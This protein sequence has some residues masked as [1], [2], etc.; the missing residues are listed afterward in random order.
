MAVKKSKA[1]QWFKIIA[2]KM[3]DEKEIGT[4]LTFTPENLVGKTI[5]LSAIELTNDMSKYYLKLNFKITKVEGD[6]AL[7]A[8]YGFDCMHDYIARMVVRRVRRI[9]AVQN[10]VTKDGVKITVKS[11]ATIS[12]KATSS[13]EVKFRVFISD[14][15][16]NI[17]ENLTL[18]DFV[19]R[20]IANEIKAKV[21]KE[22][23]RIYPVRNFEIRKAELIL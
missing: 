4:T 12:K 11:L 2:P 9:D 13:V 21:L 22:G 18:E 6:R 1:K 17:V 14:I 5:S 8:F 20:M 10:L 19:K 16:K 23:R 15:M 7:T 3:F